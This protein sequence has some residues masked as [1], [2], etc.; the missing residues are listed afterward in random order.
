MPS[1]TKQ[2]GAALRAEVW[3][4]HVNVECG[5]L[6]PLWSV[7][8][9][10]D[11]GSL[12]STYSTILI[13]NL[14]IMKQLKPLPARRKVPVAAGKQTVSLRNAGENLS[15]NESQSSQTKRRA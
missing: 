8:T 14:I 12:E 15:L 11:F 6:S 3:F 1:Q 10:R 9:C 2:F 5:D 4:V 13:R 7:A